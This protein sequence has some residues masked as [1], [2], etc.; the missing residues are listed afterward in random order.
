MSK[1]T[2]SAFV[3]DYYSYDLNAINKPKTK[4]KK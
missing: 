3:G 2:K 1:L 4:P